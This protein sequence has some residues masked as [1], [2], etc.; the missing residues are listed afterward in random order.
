MPSTVY[1]LVVGGCFYQSEYE[2]SQHREQDAERH[3]DST[4]AIDFQDF[5][6]LDRSDNHRYYQNQD[7]QWDGDYEHLDPIPVVLN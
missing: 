3:P 7:P 2:D 5:L 6:L 1:V 4:A